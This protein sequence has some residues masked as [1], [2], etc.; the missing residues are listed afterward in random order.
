[1][2][3]SYDEIGRSTIANAFSGKVHLKS[4]RTAASLLGRSDRKNA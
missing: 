1:V 3:N 4:V 2:A